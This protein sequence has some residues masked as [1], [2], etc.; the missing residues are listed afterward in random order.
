MCLASFNCY[1]VELKAE[2]FESSFPAVERSSAN[3]YSWCSGK[4]KAVVFLEIGNDKVLSFVIVVAGYD[5]VNLVGV[6]L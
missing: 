3:E 1:D 6:G 4:P 2:F 5:I